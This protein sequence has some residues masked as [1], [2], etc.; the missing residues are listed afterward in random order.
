MVYRGQGAEISPVHILGS[1]RLYL[2]FFYETEEEKIGHGYFAIKQLKKK[3]AIAVIN[4]P[5]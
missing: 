1:A 3:Y 5:K 4:T 2:A